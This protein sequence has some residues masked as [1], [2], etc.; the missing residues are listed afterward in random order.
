VK[1]E[2]ERGQMMKEDLLKKS[3]GE[4]VDVPQ[5]QGLVALRQ[6]QG[7]QRQAF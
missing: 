3:W 1:V 4:E 6:E 7:W 2:G 5:Q